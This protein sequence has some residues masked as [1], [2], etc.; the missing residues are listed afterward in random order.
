M[1]PTLEQILTDREREFWEAASDGDGDFYRANVV[2]TGVFVFPDPASAVDKD[3]CAAIIDGN[4][5]PWA[6]YRMDDLRLIPLGDQVAV[7]TYR[8]TAQPEGAEPFSMLMSSAYV[9]DGDR[10]LMAFHQ[11]TIVDAKPL[12]EG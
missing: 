10:W 5:T 4:Q 11:Q 1:P 6:W 12:P 2:P 8:G 7:I 3:G 9:A